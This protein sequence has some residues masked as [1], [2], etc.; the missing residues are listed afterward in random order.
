MAYVGIKDGK[1]I[2]LGDI[3]AAVLADK[4][5]LA[6]FDE[7]QPDQ[8]EI[9]AT[10]RQ[11]I[12]EFA[13]AKTREGVLSDVLG[14]AIVGLAQ[15]SVALGTAKTIADVNA[16]A[17]PL[18]AIGAAIDSA[19]KSGDLVLPFMVKAGGAQAVLVDLMKLSNGVS[20]VLASAQGPA[21]Q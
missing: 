13:D 19:V 5:F 20:A 9:R 7:V 17:K 14:V 4:D 10:L 3:P 2:S 21:K 12:D 8:A 1:R 18:A 16:A 11:K 15:L 6:Q